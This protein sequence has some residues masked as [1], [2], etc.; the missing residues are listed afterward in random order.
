MNNHYDLHHSSK[1]YRKE[2]LREANKR[3]LIALARTGSERPYG[4]GRV[5]LRWSGLL[6]LLRALEISE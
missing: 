6:S 1:L 2:A 5:G 3:H 4:L